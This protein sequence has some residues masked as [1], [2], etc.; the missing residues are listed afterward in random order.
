MIQ[1]YP[2]TP[3]LMITSEQLNERGIIDIYKTDSWM[4]FQSFILIIPI[5]H[6][7]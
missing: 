5:K 6:H 7:Q 4:P 2:L 3:I 1:Y